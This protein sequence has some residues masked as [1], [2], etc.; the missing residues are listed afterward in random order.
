MPSRWL[1]PE[2]MEVHNAK[3]LNPFSLGNRNCIGK[4]LAYAEIRLMLTR[5]MW[6]FD[7]V[8]LGTN[9]NWGD[10]KAFLL[11]EKRPILVGLTPTGK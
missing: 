8:D 2:K 3:A 6:N 7:I 9:F 11:W 10:Q 5:M 1:N 4:L